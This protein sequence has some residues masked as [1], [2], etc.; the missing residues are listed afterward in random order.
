MATYLIHNPCAS[1]PGSD[2]RAHSAS[3]MRAA[4]QGVRI[5]VTACRTP[6]ST[7]SGGV[8]APHSHSPEPTTRRLCIGHMMFVAHA[9]RLSGDRNVGWSRTGRPPRP[10]APAGRP[11]RV[12]PRL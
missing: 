8:A 1:R 5:H 4:R 12:T 9:A 7:V 11:C 3:A 2:P 6:E 10:P